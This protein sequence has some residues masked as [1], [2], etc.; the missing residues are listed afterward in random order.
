MLFYKLGT[1]NSNAWSHVWQNTNRHLV[2]LFPKQANKQKS[3]PDTSPNREEYYH[4]AECSETIWSSKCHALIIDLSNT[5]KIKNHI[6]MTLTILRSRMHPVWDGSESLL[7]WNWNRSDDWV[8]AFSW[9]PNSKFVC[10]IYLRIVHSCFKKG[11]YNACF[12]VPPEMLSQRSLFASELTSEPRQRISPLTAIVRDNHK[13][14]FILPWWYISKYLFWMVTMD[15]HLRV[16][17]P[18][19]SLNVK[20]EDGG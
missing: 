1:P 11:S 3:K 16:F 10:C 19:I 17:S 18:D 13:V 8:H 12:Y 4:G 15:K 20:K 14:L 9:L 6:I 5:R 7:L 2:T